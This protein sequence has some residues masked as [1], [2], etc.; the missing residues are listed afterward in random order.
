MADFLDQNYRPYVGNR[1]GYQSGGYPTGRAPLMM[2]LAN[3]VYAI[4]QQ[5]IQQK[6]RDLASQKDQ[7]SQNLKNLL[8]TISFDTI[9]GL[10]QQVQKEHLKRLDDFSNKWT[11]KWASAG[12]VLSGPQLHEQEM[13]K[14]AIE[15]DMANMQSNVE[16]FANATNMLLQ[17]Y[18]K[19]GDTGVF[20]FQGSLNN[21]S[22]FK[23]QIGSGVDPYSLLAER[24]KP[25]D[26]A[27][28]T[29]FGK[30]FDTLAKNMGEDIADIR[31][32]IVYFKKGNTIPLSQVINSRAGAFTGD[33]RLASYD[34]GELTTAVENALKRRM[35][36]APGFEQQPGYL[37][38]LNGQGKGSKY[39]G[40]LHYA[41]SL[42]QGVLNKESSAVNA[43]KKSGNVKDVQFDEVRN[44]YIITDMQDRKKE[45]DMPPK[46]ASPDQIVEWKAAL[47]PYLPIYAKDLP[48]GWQKDIVADYN[49]YMDKNR[50]KTPEPDVSLSEMEKT[51]TEPQSA[52]DDMTT[53]KKKERFDKI[54]K[55]IEV[56]MK[57]GVKG[58]EGQKSFLGFKWATKDKIVIDQNGEK[59]TYDLTNA[60]DSKKL[61]DYIKSNNKYNE[62]DASSAQPEFTSEQEKVIKQIMEQ[63]PG[64]TRDEILTSLGLKQ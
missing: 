18:A 12:G 5:M 41:N 28:E 15:S 32:G 54:K 8:D 63:N 36:S 60:E 39:E 3:P 51:L 31:N 57:E 11:E 21:L 49:P 42:L 23:D 56:I 50:S 9:K 27:V 26:E 25:V 4:T 13:E 55:S 14:Q 33:R 24:K 38:Y 2:D 62:E 48:A 22:K 43:L 64:K 34:K 44:K 37:S 1:F 61:W 40:S 10:G 46:D 52:L 29:Y 58:S 47:Q 35:T 17:D 59:V 45:F 30:T 19:N 6:Q 53:E 7:I 16:K 20:D